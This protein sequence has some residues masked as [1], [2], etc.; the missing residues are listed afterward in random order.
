MKTILL[1]VVLFALTFCATA[2]IVTN[3]PSRLQNKIT[4]YEGKIGSRPVC[5]AMNLAPVNPG[6]GGTLTA[7]PPG[8][9]HEL[10][11]T[12]VG[13]NRDKDVYRIAVTRM[14]K[15]A[16]SSYQTTASK[17]VEF[18]GTKIIVF[19]DDFCCVV[20]ESLSAEDLKSAQKH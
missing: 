3:E 7:A 16:G 9:K 20:M 5:T 2:Q 8:N 4:Y 11:W 13:R 10:K 1:P 6:T 19:Q 18:D 14:T 17:E 12:F 15:D